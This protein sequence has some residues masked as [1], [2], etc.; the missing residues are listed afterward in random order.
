MSRVATLFPQGFLPEPEEVT[1]PREEQTT[2]VDIECVV[3]MGAIWYVSTRSLASQTNIG[4]EPTPQNHRTGSAL[5]GIL[6]LEDAGASLAYI[7]PH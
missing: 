5:L 6:L 1:V 2:K 7:T 4:Y 3:D